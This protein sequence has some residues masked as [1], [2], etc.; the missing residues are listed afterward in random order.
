MAKPPVHDEVTVEVSAIIVSAR[1]DRDGEW[2]LTLEVPA[3]DALKAAALATQ[4]ETVFKVRFTPVA[5]TDAAGQVT[6]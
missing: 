6:L 4:K 5:G 1:T 2:K 3:S